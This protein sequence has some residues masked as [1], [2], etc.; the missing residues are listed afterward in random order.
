MCVCAG[1]LGRAGRGGDRRE[2]Q[3]QLFDLTGS[4]IGLMSVTHQMSLANHVKFLRVVAEAHGKK[5]KIFLIATI[6]RRSEI[7]ACC[8]LQVS[9]SGLCQ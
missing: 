1:G 8:C 7:I 4:L 9:I 5:G 3:Q 2:G 6:E